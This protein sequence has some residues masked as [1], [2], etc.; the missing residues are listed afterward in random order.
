MEKSEFGKFLGKKISLPREKWS[1]QFLEYIKQK[2]REKVEREGISSPLFPYEQKKKDLKRYLEKLKL[3]EDDL[4]GKRIL[5]LG[6]G[7]GNFVKECIDK[8]ITNDIFG[9]DILIEPEAVQSEYRG[10]L[11]KADF[12]EEFPIKGFDPIVSYA[13]VEAPSFKGE[14]KHPKRTLYFALKALKNNGEIRI[15]PIRRAPYQSGLLGIEYARNKWEEI[16]KELE[17]KIGIKW[18][19]EPVDI[20]VSGKDK[21]VWLEELLIIRK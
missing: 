9:I 17:R 7:E 12:E 5:D 20:E 18:R 10:H 14:Q 21:D 19:I 3:T 13:G 8:K 2:Q 6:C 15:F 11:I 1:K 4:R 16:L